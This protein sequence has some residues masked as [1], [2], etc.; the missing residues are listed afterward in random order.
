M[1]L[2]L[3]W[4]NQLERLGQ[5]LAAN[6]AAETV[7][8]PSAVFAQ[9]HCIVLPEPPMQHWLE[10]YLLLDHPAHGMRIL[11]NTRTQ[12][13]YA[14]VNDWLFWM[15][16]PDE[17]RDAA[18]HPFSVG[19]MQWRIFGIL[20]QGSILAR[21][22]YA[23]LQ[24]YLA[25]SGAM[26]GLQAAKQGRWRMQLA[27][28]LAKLYDD[29]Q[30]YRPE[31]LH[32]W[33]VGRVAD[34][35]E[36]LCWQPAL[37]R[38]MTRDGLSAQTY[39]QA[40]LDLSTDLPHCRIAARH[41]AVHVFG[42]SMMPTVYMT[43]FRLLGR[44]LPVHLYVFNPSRDQWDGALTPR[45]VAKESL[46]LE[47]VVDTDALLACQNP[48]L[49]DM[50]RGCRNFLGQILD[51]TDVHATD[52][53]GCQADTTLLGM[54]QNAVLDN[55][56]PGLVADPAVSHPDW[57]ASES[58]APSILVHSCHSPMRELEVLRDCIYRWFEQDP[59]LQP[60]Q[61]QVLVADMETYGPYIDAVFAVDRSSDANGLI[62]YAVMD[63]RS[64]GENAVA[65]AFDQL[66]RLPESRFTAMDVMDLLQFES[67]HL[68]FGIAD[69]DLPVIGSW[70]QESGI[71]WGQDAG[72]R[73]ELTGVAFTEQTTWQH[74]L[75]RLLVGYALTEASAYDRVGVL[76]CDRVEGEQAVLL[77]K[78]VRFVDALQF[79][80]RDMHAELRTP[81]VWVDY[82][83]QCMDQFFV[84]TEATYLDV[85]GLR[86]AVDGLQRSSAAAG[87]EG[88]IGIEVVRDLLSSAT[89]ATAR[90]TQSGNKVLFCNLRTGAAAPRPYLCLLGMGDGCFPRPDNRPA[91]DLLRQGSR[92]GDPSLRTADRAAFLEA[93]MAVRKHLHISYV[94]QDN[95]VNQ[96]MPAATVVNQ[97]CEYAGKYFGKAGG[98]CV[99]IIEHKLHPFHPA[100]FNPE[101]EGYFSY[102]REN[103]IAATF[104]A[105][106]GHD[107]QSS[108]AVGHA[109]NSEPMGFA[110]QP[111]ASG[112]S[113]PGRIGAQAASA[114]PAV[115]LDAL[116][117]FFKN[118][119][120]AFYTQTLKVRLEQYDTLQLSEDE[121]F[122]PDMLEGWQVNARIVDA[123][124]RG[125]H[126]D[127]VYWQLCETGIV[128]LGGWGK[129]WFTAT[130][131]EIYEVLSTTSKHDA[132][133]I[134]TWLQEQVPLWPENIDVA[135]AS[136]R[137]SGNAKGLRD[138][139]QGV[140]ALDYRYGSAKVHEVLASWIRHLFVC[141]SGQPESRI[142]LHR[143]KDKPF[144]VVF[145]PLSA[146]DAQLHLET[147]GRYYAGGLRQ[148]LAFTPEMAFAYIQAEVENRLPGKK[149]KDPFEMAERQWY[150]GYMHFGNDQDPYYRA[151]FGERVPLDHPDF[152]PTATAI[153]GPVWQ[154]IE[155][156]AKEG[157]DA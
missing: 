85:V 136:F 12:M 89:C 138:V 48:F 87:Y 11:T 55:T 83:Q 44:L 121:V 122:A 69:D 56:Q 132:R 46:R 51:A 141:A 101:Q 144:D 100:Y 60:R 153:W 99:P 108:L 81:A 82:L 38:E 67:I 1:H 115:E 7:D 59:G 78:L 32:D 96:K 25:A 103:Y 150:S 116:L 50:G 14:F 90:G 24:R 114:V 71:R 156:S 135:T 117:R 45:Q 47:G 79:R 29:Y 102:D 39:L 26:S 68:R 16:Q 6:L 43:F 149:E 133:P 37:W 134:L 95:M 125:E 128:P 22:E 30:V 20:Q 97:L 34:V 105:R 5:R 88:K 146:S 15:K 28:T 63:R 10:Q 3:Y 4:S 17:K 77:G 111:Q 123:I 124:C 120:R 147:I 35:P 8:A 145:G 36:A 152:V 155:A 142:C 126:P 57:P 75:D 76:P 23:P 119:A 151:A 112:L 139:E 104:V 74:G 107:Q 157:A 98:D 94:G 2:R 42:V 86:R 40:F 131:E 27:G 129:S 33:Q 31:M 64:S 58:V 127:G 13:L 93:F 137:I 130:W 84:R 53:F 52:D 118:P 9:E 49:A 66:L 62:P 143:K 61:I 92:Y 41:P 19:A 65:T 154:A 110:V 91:Y 113:G 73:A 72:Q 80:A 109:A 18:A 106:E 70:I 21:S 148:C 54:L 140:S